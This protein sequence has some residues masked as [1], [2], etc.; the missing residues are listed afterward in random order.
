M[1]LWLVGGLG[2]AKNF[3]TST[4]GMLVMGAACLAIYTGVVAHIAR[5]G[6]ADRVQTRII[7]RTHRVIQKEAGRVE[8]VT[9]R[10]VVWNRKAE[11]E[12]AKARKERGALLQEIER[13]SHANDGVA[14]LGADSLRRLAALG[15]SKGLSL[16]PGSGSPGAA[17]RAAQPDTPGAVP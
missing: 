14:C 3:L 5:Q 8:T 6:V 11:R 10:V 16:Q 1:P 9:K 12:L 15:R 13:A 17:D 4:L 7:N 2:A